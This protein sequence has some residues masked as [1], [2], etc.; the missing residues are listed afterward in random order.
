MTIRLLTLLAFVAGVPAF[1][2]S[3]PPSAATTTVIVVRHAERA[4]TDSDSPL[5]AQGRERAQGLAHLLRDTPLRA[6]ITSQYVRTKETA[7]PIARQKQIAPDVMP[8]DKLDAVIDRIKSFGGGTVL[9][10]HH[11]NTVTTIVE[12]LGGQAA[13]MPDTE[14]DRVMIVTVT[15]AGASVLTLRFGTPPAR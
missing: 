12:K 2:Q 6:I 11:S 1:A 10:V 5:S 13:P 3:T 9:V 7:E 4:S 8:A 14:Y 15:P